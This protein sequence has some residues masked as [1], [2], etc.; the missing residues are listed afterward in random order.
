MMPLSL[1]FI[2]AP[3]ILSYQP[4]CALHRCLCWILLLFFSVFLVLLGSPRSWCEL[5]VRD[6]RS[7]STPSEVNKESIEHL[8]IEDQHPSDLSTGSS[9]N[10]AAKMNL[11]D[12]GILVI[13]EQGKHSPTTTYTFKVF[14]FSLCI[15]YGSKVLLSIDRVLLSVAFMF[16]CCLYF[17]IH[18]T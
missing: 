14:Q 12:L 3:L 18:F 5:R 9:M 4:L 6:W 8:D 2:I 7:R 13:N 11:E 17:L 15:A 10:S 16:L 1:G